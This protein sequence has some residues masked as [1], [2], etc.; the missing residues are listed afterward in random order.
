MADPIF[1]EVGITA[2]AS[3]AATANALK[4]GIVEIITQA[5]LTALANVIWDSKVTI[6]AITSLEPVALAYVAQS[7]GYTGTLSSGD[8]LE[9]DC[10]KMTV[11]LNGV[12]V[13]ANLTGVFPL[14]YAGANV[15]RW[16]DDDEDRDVDLEVKHRPRYL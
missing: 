10:D 2:V 12:N 5:S 1:G 15:L 16:S 8:V 7:L 3:V 14:L 4:S 13:R 11:K 6:T 9:I